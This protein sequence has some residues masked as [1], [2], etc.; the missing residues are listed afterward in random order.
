MKSSPKDCLLETKLFG[1]REDKQG[2]DG[3]SSGEQSIS[4]Q[5][6]LEKFK[7]F[8]CGHKL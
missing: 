1:E 2:Q 5:L 4:E 8:T 3:S 6:S 7:A